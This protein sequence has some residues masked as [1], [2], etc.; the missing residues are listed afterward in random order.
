[1]F[2]EEIKMN[3]EPPSPAILPA[4][5]STLTTRDRRGSIMVS[6]DGG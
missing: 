5:T 4:A 2:N 6:Q 1:M 3:N